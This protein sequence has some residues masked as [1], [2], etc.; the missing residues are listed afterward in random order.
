M[1]NEK[2]R[3]QL[4]EAMRAKDEVAVATLRMLLSSLNY[5]RIDKPEMTE[6]DEV[7]VVQF[8]AKKRKDALV[9]Y[10]DAQSKMDRTDIGEKIEREQKELEVLEKYLPE[11]MSEEEVEKIVDKVIEKIGASGMGDTGKVMGAVM[12]KVKGKADG[13]MVSGMVKKKLG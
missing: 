5:A 2:A 4:G 7:K 11:Q 1:I 12:G 8:E 10:K 3:K 9:A 6:E 13:G